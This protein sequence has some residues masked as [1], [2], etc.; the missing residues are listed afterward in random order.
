MGWLAIRY[1]SCDSAGMRSR[2][3]ISVGLFALSACA[4]TPPPQPAPTTSTVQSTSATVE[5]C[6]LVCEKP[7]VTLATPATP[8]VTEAAVVNVDRVFDAM[9]DDLLACYKTR[10]KTYA[11]AHAFMTVDLVLEADGHVRTVETTGGAMLGDRGIHCITDRIKKAT[12]D[13]IPGGGTRRVQ[14]PLNFR[15][16]APE[17]T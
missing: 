16:V 11:Q 4:S 14:V 6:E 1:G 9:H 10:L 3:L 12:F 2:I 17:S 13:P 8:D 15:R 7:Q 5:G